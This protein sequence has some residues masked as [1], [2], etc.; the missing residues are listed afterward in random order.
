METH[1]SGLAVLSGEPFI[2]Q[3]CGQQADH[4]FRYLRNRADRHFTRRGGHGDLFG[5]A[6]AARHVPCRHLVRLLHQ[7]QLFLT[8]FSGL[9]LFLRLTLQLLNTPFQFQ[10]FLVIFRRPCF[11]KTAQLPVDVLIGI[12]GGTD[13][14][15]A[16]V[17]VLFRQEYLVR[18][19]LFLFQRYRQILERVHFLLLFLFKGTLFVGGLFIR[20]QPLVLR[21]RDIHVESL[22]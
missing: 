4:P 17:R 14:R 18:H 12:G 19:R 15:T 13:R 5:F 6:T 16:V 3:G 10:R 22:P 11:I 21:H 9:A 1:V 20:Q 2:G 8:V 7:P